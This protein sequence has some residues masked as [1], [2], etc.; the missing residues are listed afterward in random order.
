MDIIKEKWE[1]ILYTVKLEHE[2]TDVSFDTWLKPLK[3]HSF[4]K[5]G[6]ANTLYI[7]IP[8]EQQPA[9]GYIKK[10]YAPSASGC[11]R[12]NHRSGLFAGV[13]PPRRSPETG[14]K[15]GNCYF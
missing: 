7:L 9:F 11:H 15:K 3:V 14:G 13:Y 10:K 2:L 5:N 1:E 8:A 12:G 6:S 4:E